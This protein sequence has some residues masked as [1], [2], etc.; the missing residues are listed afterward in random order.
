M[1][2]WSVW[3]ALEQVR[4]KKRELDPLFARAGI[5]PELTTIANRICLDLKRSPLTMPL[6]T[7]D[8]TRD[9]EAMDMYYEGYARQY[10]EAFYKAENL[11]RFAWVP[12]A[13]PIGAL[14]S[15]EI[16]RLR[17]QLKNEQGKTLDFTDLEALLFNYVRLDHPTLALPP[18]LLSNRRRELAEIA[19]YPLLV[20][21]SHAEMQNNNVPPLLSEAF[22]T[23]LSE[24][25]Q[26][27]LVSPWLHCPLI[28]QWYVTLALDTGLARK[29]RDALDDQ[30]TASLLKRRWPS[31]SRWMPQ[32]EFA[33]QCWYI[34]LSLLALVS[35]F[36]EWW[37]L[38]V[39]M[40][41]W[42]HLS[43]GGT[44]GKEKR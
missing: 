26:S 44:G 38:A 23:Q 37:W 43:L 31:L 30:L 1:A 34:S 15:A 2:E 16:A 7:G 19:G 17:G 18:D 21:H 27:Y 28:S 32:F 5:A 6:L 20:Q 11:L 22:K 10:E 25:L 33:D 14:I 3:K 12:E 4:Q 40:V 8:K 35:L 9:A 13:L 41:I 42:L 36:M 29:K 39:P 24:H